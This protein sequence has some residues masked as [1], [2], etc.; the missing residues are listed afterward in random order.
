MTPHFISFRRPE[1]LKAA[2]RVGSG[3]LGAVRF[4]YYFF[5]FL[6]LETKNPSLRWAYPMPSAATATPARG[7]EMK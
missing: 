6:L 1:V 7:N 3:R 5:F 4:T 2:G